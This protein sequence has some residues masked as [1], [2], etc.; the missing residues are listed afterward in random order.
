MKRI[1]RITFLI[2]VCSLSTV[3]TFNSCSD[4]TKVVLNSEE[5]LNPP[6]SVGIYAWW[7][8]LDNAITKEGITR[9]LE[10][11]KQQG[12]A[13]ATI[14]NIGLFDEKDMGVPKVIFGTDQWYDMFKWALEE[15]NR[16]GITIGAHNC[17]GWSTSGGPWITPEM[18][19]K[20]YVWS[21]TNVRG[22]QTIDMTLPEPHG[23]N[24]YYEDAAIIAYPASDP[25]NSFQLAGPQV[26]INDTIDGKILFDGNPFSNV[27]LRG[28]AFIDIAFNEMFTADK[29][30]VHLR[31]ASSW[32]SLKNIRS[33][34]EIMASRD[35]RNYTHVMDFEIKGVNRTVSIEIPGTSSK[36]YRIKLKRQSE[37]PYYTR[38][39]L[40]EIE[41]LK[42]GEQPLYSPSL[43]YHL[44]KTVSTRPEEISDVF[45]AGSLTDPLNSVI[46]SKVIDLQGNMDSNGQLKWDV[47]EGNWTIIRF[48]YTTTGVVNGPATNAGR[49]LECD[50]MDTTALNLHFRSF[51]LK[52]IQ[53][54]GNFTGNTF[55]YI[56]IDSWEC[57]YQNWTKNF[58]EEF[59][60]RNGY[61]LIPWIP[62]LIG[63]TENNT[64]ETEAFL[65]DFRKTIADLIEE[66]YYKHFTELCHREGMDLHAEVIYGG[67]HYP[68]LNILRSNSYMDVPMW[69]FWTNQD[70]DGFVHYMPVQNI[71][72][73]KPMYAAVVYDK[74]VVPSE[75][76]TGYAHYSE[77]PWDL[78]LYGDR[79]YCS[80][81][82][83]MVLHSYVH[84]P[85]ERKPG[86]TL[87]PFA[88]HFNRHNTWW[89]HVSEWFTYQ[90]RVQYILQKGQPVADI[91]YFIGDQL[92]E[93]QKNNDLYNV[94]YGYNTQLCNMD[95]LLNHSEVRNGMIWLENGLTYKIL[96]LPDNDQMEYSTLQ[97][98][99]TLIQE[100]V[101]VVGPKPAGVLSYTDRNQNNTDLR[102]LA[103]EVWGE[104][105]GKN[106]TE[107]NYGRG[108][109][110][111]GNSLQEVL[112]GM[113][114][115]PDLKVLKSDTVNLLFIHKQIETREVYFLVNQ[116]DKTIQTECIF[117]VGGMSPEI[118]NPQNGR[119]LKPAVYNEEEEVIRIPV[120]FRPKESLFIVFTDEKP[121]EHIVAVQ[122]N[123]TQ[124][125]PVSGTQYKNDPLPEITS[126]GSAFS[127][128]SEQP[129]EFTMTSDLGEEYSLTTPGNETVE[130]KDFSGTI[131]F[132]GS[133]G[134]PDPVEISNFR[135]WNT[136]DNPEIKYY[137]G[138]AKYTIPFTLPENFLT[139]NDP[140]ELSIGGIKAT[141][142]VYLNGK[143]LGYAWM[144]GQRFN[145]T[146]IL[147][148]GENR[149][150][151]TV[152][153]VYRNRLIGDL[154][155][156]GEIKSLWTTSP[157]KDF[158]NKEMKLQ[159][160][161]INGP[162]TVTRIK[163][164]LIN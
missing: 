65:H 134:S 72:F 110:I 88:S 120:C 57:N 98:I 75:A 34:F 129:G 27:N 51:P 96:M 14:L 29:I 140:L 30:A 32:E 141:G 61:S 137:S 146:E 28:D 114:I 106:V 138:K 8:W 107:N 122:Q 84:Q 97:R 39:N 131:G 1:L 99:A 52:L 38:I 56:F 73:D 156:Y 62:V 17:D 59:E 67:V 92:P 20:Q 119:I 164:K 115:Q 130:I 142:E 22:G 105:D 102:K 83:R 143:K 80:G 49:G 159:D 157:V 68:P 4:K 69:E 152:A 86:M 55:K 145:I 31:M 133:E 111:W 12:I 13:G 26:T 163:T 153:N 43:M 100:G 16:L 6:E 160:S 33:G 127:V 109:V 35:G 162:V 155:Q 2:S 41:L 64:E 7:H 94:P 161:G 135:Y 124:I 158:L 53:N 37:I 25:P 118:W 71:S 128:I 95:I 144:P 93:Y 58:P 113:N 101:T 23:N 150:E 90:S 36:Y 10:A 44:E 117:R 104:I 77:S 60:R 132:D 82:N 21:K 154:A 48:G 81:I 50:K 151:V 54:A 11:M 112:E 85:T 18:S 47:P 42:Q 63:E 45:V 125:F 15:A 108:K 87:G 89:E 149:L 5:F 126:D 40:S 121:G 123:G 79:A 76:Y 9:D 46:S 3:L 24:D 148:Q 19:M 139:G 103:D 66:N 136:F 147:V 78:K 74:P 70:E 91:L 116:E